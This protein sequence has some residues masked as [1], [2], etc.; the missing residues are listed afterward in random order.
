[1]MRNEFVHSSI[2]Y[3]SPVDFEGAL[4]LNIAPKLTIH[5]KG[6]SPPYICENTQGGY[7]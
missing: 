1:M 6:R 5:S 3:K 7:L 4:R 2:G